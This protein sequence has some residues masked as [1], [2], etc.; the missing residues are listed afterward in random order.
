MSPFVHG[1]GLYPLSTQENA[2]VLLRLIKAY[3]SFEFSSIF[4]LPFVLWA[5]IVDQVHALT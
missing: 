3:L 2:S 4:A 5:S 1:L